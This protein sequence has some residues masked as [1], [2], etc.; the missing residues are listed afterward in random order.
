MNASTNP[1]K[2]EAMKKLLI[3][4]CTELAKL[5][6]YYAA[7]EM[8]AD[9]LGF[10]IDET[11]ASGSESLAAPLFFW[12]EAVEKFSSQDTVFFVATGYKSMRAREDVYTRVKQ[13]GYGLANVFGK[14]SYIAEDIAM[15]DN[16]FIM[17]G[18]V[19]EPGTVLGANNVVW[20]NA[21]ICHDS[22]IGNH[23]FI[24]ANVTLGGGVSVGDRNFFGFSSIVLQG[25]KIQSD[26]M[27]GAGSL[28][29]S[30]LDALCEY[31]GCP[32]K[33]HARIDPSLGVCV[34]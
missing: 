21:T 16:N 34:Q 32:A 15:S 33:E 22:R 29:R 12:P 4:G 9:V 28:V 25:R 31:R 23:N 2:A 18:A 5:A 11:H 6:H 17:P 8:G 13:A 19:L 26:T 3:F 30:D 10:V 24:A 14:S 27:I 20:S 1:I 7:K